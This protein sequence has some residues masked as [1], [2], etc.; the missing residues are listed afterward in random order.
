MELRLDAQNAFNHP[1]FGSPSTALNN[2]STFG[3]ITSAGGN[4]LV[5]AGLRFAF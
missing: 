4:R 3:V 1:L 5:E 2:K